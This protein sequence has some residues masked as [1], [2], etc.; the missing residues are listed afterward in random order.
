MILRVHSEQ[1]EQGKHAVCTKSVQRKGRRS[2]IGQVRRSEIRSSR[3]AHRR[4][5]ARD[6]VALGSRH[7]DGAQQHR[8]QRRVGSLQPACCLITMLVSPG[9]EPFGGFTSEKPHPA[10]IRPERFI[11][12]GQGP[13]DTTRPDSAPPVGASTLV[14]TAVRRGLSHGSWR[15]RAG[16]AARSTQSRAI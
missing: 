7:R 5:T 4:T 6:R 2:T 12:S 16:C 11:F 8:G 10:M 13:K 1:R 3:A 15:S 14:A 9:G